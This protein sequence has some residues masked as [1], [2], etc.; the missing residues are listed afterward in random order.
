MIIVE[1][2]HSHATAEDGRGEMNHGKH[3]TTR[4][5]EECNRTGE[6]P[7]CLDARWGRRYDGLHI[8][9]SHA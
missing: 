6:G 9:R 5:L 2:R 4:K 3:G 1:R 7:E 8:S